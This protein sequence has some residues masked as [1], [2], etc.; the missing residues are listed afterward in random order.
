MSRDYT[1]RN[2][3]DAAMANRRQMMGE[4]QHNSTNAFVKAEQDRLKSKGGHAPRMESDLMEFN[5]KMANNGAH[6]QRFAKELTAGIDHEAY[7]V[8]QKPDESQD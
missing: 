3:K 4:S 7:P 5:A 1:L 6:A 2:G 8:R